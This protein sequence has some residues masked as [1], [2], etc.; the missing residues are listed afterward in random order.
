MKRYLLV[1]VLCFITCTILSQQVNISLFKISRE[2]PADISQWENLSVNAIAT[3]TNLLGGQKNSKMVVQVKINGS[4]VCG[5][6]PQN[7]PLIESLRTKVITAKNITAAL[8]NC[9]LEPGQYSLCIRFYN[10]DNSSISTEEC[11]EFSVTGIKPDDG[12]MKIP[13]ATI[14]VS[15]PYLCQNNII[16]RFIKTYESI[17]H[18]KAM[19]GDV[20]A[21]LDAGHFGYQKFFSSGYEG[22]IELHGDCDQGSL[23]IGNPD[24]RISIEKEPTEFTKWFEYSYKKTG[25][26]YDFNFIATSGMP[27]PPYPGLDNTGEEGRKDIRPKT[28]GAWANFIDYDPVS[29]VCDGFESLP[30]S[31]DI[32][33]C[34]PHYSHILIPS[35]PKI[36]DIHKTFQN[37]GTFSITQKMLEDAKPPACYDFPGKKEIE[38]ITYVLC[39]PELRVISW[40]AGTDLCKKISKKL[41]DVFLRK[42]PELKKRNANGWQTATLRGFVEEANDPANDLAIDHTS[43]CYSGGLIPSG[44]LYPPQAYPPSPYNDWDLKISPDADVRYLGSDV[45]PDI[46]GLE[47]EKWLLPKKY[48]PV[49]GDYLQSMGRW[50]IDCG[51]PQD[52]DLNNGFYTEIHPPELLVS[53]NQVG[54]GAITEARTIVVGSWKGDDLKFLVW[55]V[56]RPN[57]KSILKDTIVI[58]RQ[59]LCTIEIRKVPADNPNHLECIIRRTAA[60]PPS[61][62]QRGFILYNC[63]RGFQGVIQAW[64]EPP[65]PIIF[66]KKDVGPR[67]IFETDDSHKAIIPDKNKDSK[68][69]YLKI[70]PDKLNTIISNNSQFIIHGKVDCAGMSENDCFIFYH[71]DGDNAG[72]WMSEKTDIN[73]NFSINAG[74][75]KK[76]IIV[77]AS[78]KYNFPNSHAEVITDSNYLS[79]GWN[80]NIIEFSGLL[81]PLFNNLNTEYGFQDVSNFQPNSVLW[82]QLSGK[83]QN[84]NLMTSFV[85]QFQNS[86]VQLMQP[87]ESASQDENEKAIYLHIAGLVDSLNNP[88]ADLSQCL[89]FIQRPQDINNLL[90]QKAMQRHPFLV[91]P[92]TG[93]PANN[94]LQNS[95]YV[96]LNALKGRGASHVRIRAK[97]LAGNESS[98]FKLVTEET[99]IT[100]SEG[101]IKFS[102]TSGLNFSEGKIILEVIDNPANPWFLPKFE[103]R[104]FLFPPV[105]VFNG[106]GQNGINLNDFKIKQASILYQAFK[107][108][109]ANQGRSDNL[110]HNIKMDREFLS[111]MA[112]VYESDLWENVGSFLMLYQNKILANES[113]IINQ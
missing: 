61:I 111:E 84:Q 104:P 9:M 83:I 70:S 18:I 79:R 94:S 7:A 8:G 90:T 88:V 65:P 92:L 63:F 44:P 64:W 46:V 52:D 17:Y 28:D 15:M 98:G 49:H 113:V 11:R 80:N 53:S 95:D 20:V 87:D 110:P 91:F 43:N 29:V 73:G 99:G 24:R 68:S 93:T 1:P 21:G 36:A 86:F 25:G 57:D 76:Y 100:D 72:D 66:T 56:P 102:F 37:P 3:S 55:P 19:E 42:C 40:I 62:Q 106:G 50:V 108:G 14:P 31:I 35:G 101:N 23:W 78:M 58:E 45:K 75:G 96:L 105:N 38:V 67:I 5:N 13:D 27:S 47:V 12:R 82:Q 107:M 77:P 71:L 103:S 51:H 16:K 89:D 39:P 2:L 41:T 85:K 6:T 54:D 74:Y 48:Q 97:L 81:N 32:G 30:G 69:G 112:E 34:I 10:A 59:D 109:F 60:A 4:P 22:C 26:I 33:T